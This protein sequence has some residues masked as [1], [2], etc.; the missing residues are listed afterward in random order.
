MSNFVRGLELSE[1]FYLEAAK[2][3]LDTHFPHLAY[4]AALLGWS[5]EV[6]GYDDAESTDHN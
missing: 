2:P 1:Q 3:I 5:S 6:L 4:S